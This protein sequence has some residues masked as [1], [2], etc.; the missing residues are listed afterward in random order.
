MQ[1]AFAGQTASGC[2]D[3]PPR[4]PLI[5]LLLWIAKTLNQRGEP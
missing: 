3:E 5:E 4:N 1:H 2:S